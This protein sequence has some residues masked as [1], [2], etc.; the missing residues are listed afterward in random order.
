MSN[1]GP[2]VEVPISALLAVLIDDVDGDRKFEDVANNLRHEVRD[3]L[4]AFV[5]IHV[6]STHRSLEC[7]DQRVFRTSD[8]GLSL[9]NDRSSVVCGTGEVLSERANEHEQVLEVAGSENVEEKEAHVETELLE[10]DSEATVGRGLT[11]SHGSLRI[12]GEL[13]GVARAPYVID[14]NRHVLVAYR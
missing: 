4:G 8:V 11:L 13:E 7:E 9:I 3:S 6:V 12:L 1:L 10:H 5:V 2:N 14:E